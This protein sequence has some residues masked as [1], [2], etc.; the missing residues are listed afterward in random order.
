MSISISS[1][2]KSLGNLEPKYR[3]HYFKSDVR[4]ASLNLLICLSSNLLFIFNDFQMMGASIQFYQYLIARLSFTLSILCS[5]LVLQK[6]RSIATY[7]RTL[8]FTVIVYMLFGTYMSTNCAPQLRTMQTSIDLLMICGAYVLFATKLITMLLATVP[9][10]FSAL[11]NHWSGEGIVSSSTPFLI[12]IF[13][14]ANFFGLVFYAYVHNSRRQEYKVRLEELAACENYR[15]LATIDDLTGIFNRRK[16]LKLAK[17]E[18][19]HFLCT[20]QPLSVVLIDIDYF[21]KLNDTYGHLT[22]DK[23][24]TIFTTFISNKIRSTDIWGRIGGEEFVL[25][26]PNTTS[27][28]AKNISEHFRLDTNNLRVLANGVSIEITIS[29]GVTNANT[30]DS[31]LHKV[32]QRADIALY[33]AKQAGRNK[34]VVV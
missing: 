16:L 27:E 32:L 20:A 17:K 4:Q 6:S 22:G 26:L 30:T 10:T 3:A 15:R 8:L 13:L 19:N 18:F 29:I 23:I 24:L 12:I 25:I 21:K 9:L 7:D 1:P 34:V 11:F 28:E 2:V 14:T 33:Q 31:A 5:V